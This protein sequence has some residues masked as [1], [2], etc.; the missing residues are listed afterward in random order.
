MAEFEFSL[1]PFLIGEEA[2]RNY[3]E[4]LAA[5]L[6]YHATEKLPHEYDCSEGGLSLFLRELQQRAL[7]TGWNRILTIPKDAADPNAETINLITDFSGVSL[8]QVRAHATTYTNTLSR[9]AQDSDQLY[10]CI[11]ESVSKTGWYNI[12]RFDREEYRI[13]GVPSGTCFL[14]VIIREAMMRKVRHTKLR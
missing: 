14:K 5:K 12:I 1:T 11:M 13:D 9:A 3:A 7:T 6:Y 4:P 10:R 2:P 8:E